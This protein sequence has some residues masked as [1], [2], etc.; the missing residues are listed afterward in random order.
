MTVER[1]TKDLDFENLTLHSV[2]LLRRSQLQIFLYKTY[3]SS[4]NPFSFPF[5]HSVDAMRSE[6][7]SIIQRTKNTNQ[8]N[9][10]SQ[11]KNSAVPH[12]TQS[13][14]ENQ[15]TFDTQTSTSNKNEKQP[16]NPSALS[17][18]PSTCTTITAGLS[19]ADIEKIPEYQARIL[20][21]NY[22]ESKGSKVSDDFYVKIPAK[23]L[24]SQIRLAR[25]KIS[26]QAAKT[27]VQ[28]NPN[29]YHP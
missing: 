11:N 16:E 3:Q 8:V 2:R 15:N 20:L 13:Q 27:H 14:P 1:K 12:A 17:F 24:S 9:N 10:T 21:K 23:N 28:M 26:K 29:A 4:N 22:A 25:D 18:N 7:I 5:V 19:N 6:L